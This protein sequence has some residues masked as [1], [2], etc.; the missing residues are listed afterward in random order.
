MCH[1]AE[2]LEHPQAPGAP[3]YPSPW[4]STHFLPPTQGTTILDVVL[5]FSL[6]YMKN[7]EERKFPNKHFHNNLDR[8]FFFS[9]FL[10]KHY[11]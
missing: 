3:E 8:S 5:I 1:P 10:N 11:Y 4:P 7:P 2:E 9:F 6:A